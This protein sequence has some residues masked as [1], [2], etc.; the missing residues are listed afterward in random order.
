M[1]EYDLLVLSPNEFEDFSRDLLQVK[2]G[3]FIESFKT[4]KDGG[5]DLRFAKEKKH[6]CIVQAKRYSTYT[7]LLSNLKKEVPKVK[8]LNPSKYIIC[9]TVGLTPHNKQEIHN[10]FTPYID[11]TE[12]ILGKE[13]LNNLLSQNKNIE[14]KYY[15]LWIASVN[16]LNKVLHSKIYNQSNFELDEIKEQIKLYVQNKSFNKALDILNDHR[17]IIISGIPGIG[18]TTLSRILTFYLLSNDFQ[19]FV[20]LS[21]N[22]DDGY[23]YFKE[24]S[25]QIF[26]FDDFLGRNFFDAKDLPKN[27]DKIVKFIQKIKQSPDK[28]LIL[29]TREYILN[30]AKLSYE[31]FEINNIEIAKCILDLSTYTSVIKA[32]IFY[33]HLFYGNVPMEHIDNLLEGKRYK[34]LI[35]HKN[36]NPRII[37]TIIKKQVWNNCEPNQFYNALKRFFDNPESVWLQSFENS[38]D[39]FSQYT[40]LVLASLG[41]PVLLKDLEKAVKEF[42]IKNNYKLLITFDSIK[43]SRSIKELENT[44][45]ITNADYR[46]ELSVE[47]QN[48]SIYDFLANYLNCKDDIIDDIINSAVFADQLLTIFTARKNVDKY[49]NKVKLSKEQVKS[50]AN[51]LL[52]IEENLI[53]SRILKVNINKSEKYHYSRRTGFIYGF[54]LQLKNEYASL[55]SRIDDFIYRQFQK[56]ILFK[57]SFDNYNYFEIL[58]ELDLSRLTFN[59]EQIIDHY[60]DNSNW[61]DDLEYFDNFKEIFPI[62]YKETIVSDNFRDK[63]KIIVDREVEEIENSD[64]NDVRYKVEKIQSE[65]DIDLEEVI[66]IL[67]QKE[68]DM[69]AYVDH[70]IEMSMEDRH[71]REYDVETKEDELIDEIFNSLKER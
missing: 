62:T 44:F 7:S 1:T 51:R 47:Y 5:I 16:I 22:I 29:A 37:E 45:I 54:L 18:K 68:A 48:P 13:D 25:R 35:S 67:H 60:I 50:I 30:Q 17:Y 40:L 14:E 43:F 59:D 6:N 52:E 57:D 42:I 39:K 21:D 23:K 9:T 32:K 49:L 65:Y 58:K 66:A 31:A 28:V 36:Y 3:V 38:L 10:L 64:A 26:L 41:T 27:D 70:Q 55:D 56:H 63:T 69:D 20:Y 46:G 34:N 24:D 53:S 19:E 12:D 61:L 71:E 33:N 11:S 2:L 15:K 8:A 4:G